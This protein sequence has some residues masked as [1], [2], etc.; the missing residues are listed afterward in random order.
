MWLHSTLICN[1]RIPCTNGPVSHQNNIIIFNGSKAHQSLCADVFSKIFS[2][3][4]CSCFVAIFALQL[5]FKNIPR[6]RNIWTLTWPMECDPF[7]LEKYARH[8]CTGNN[9]RQR[10]AGTISQR[11]A[12]SLPPEAPRPGRLLRP[13]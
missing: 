13:R 7:R 3:V 12:A 10:S 5:K 4:T 11:L 6:K 9:T 1:Y 8:P 2:T